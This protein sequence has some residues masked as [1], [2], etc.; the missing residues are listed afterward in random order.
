MRLAFPSIRRSVPNGRA[1]RSRS[2][3]EGRV[4]QRQS[5]A[6]VAWHREDGSVEIR[7]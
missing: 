1:D 7:G 4:R 3:H 6:T 2:A 5:T